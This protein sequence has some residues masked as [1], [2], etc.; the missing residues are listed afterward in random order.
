VA[1][2]S[3]PVYP[4]AARTTRIVPTSLDR[5]PPDV[6][7]LRRIPNNVLNGGLKYNIPEASPYFVYQNEFCIPDE[8]LV[9]C[10]TQRGWCK[11]RRVVKRLRYCKPKPTNTIFERGQTVSHKA[12]S[13]RDFL[14]AAATSAAAA[15]ILGVAGTVG[16]S[17]AAART[18]HHP[19]DGLGQPVEKANIEA[20]L[21]AFMA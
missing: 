5:L 10:I 11:I 8:L 15:Q 2:S 7:L 21:A 16:H 20:G 13:R 1:A 19:Q 14:K 4:L 17:F 3:Q 18:G 6:V 12:I 9:Y